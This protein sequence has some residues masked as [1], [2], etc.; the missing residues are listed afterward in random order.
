MYEVNLIRRQL[1]FGMKKKGAVAVTGTVN[2]VGVTGTVVT[3]ALTGSL[4]DAGLRHAVCLQ[5]SPQP[6]LP[7]TIR[8][9]SQMSCASV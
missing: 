1:R 5:A 6:D 7:I 9:I 8:R 2:A 3:V 4:V